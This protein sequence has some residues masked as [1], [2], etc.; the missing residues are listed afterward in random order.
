MKLRRSIGAEPAPF[1]KIPRD[2]RGRHRRQRIIREIYRL[3][4]LLTEQLGH[5]NDDLDRRVERS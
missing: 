1:G 3:E 5:I 4:A 2:P